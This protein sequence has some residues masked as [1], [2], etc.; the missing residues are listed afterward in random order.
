MQRKCGPLGIPKNTHLIY[1][2]L[3]LSNRRPKLK[4]YRLSLPIRFKLL[5]DIMAHRLRMLAPERPNQAATPPR[6]HPVLGQMSASPLAASHLPSAAFSRRMS[7]TAIAAAPSSPVW[8]A[9]SEL[10]QYRDRSDTLSLNNIRRTL[11]LMEDTIIFSLIERAQFARNE[12]IYQ[13]GGVP[14]P[15]WTLDGHQMSLLEY[16]LRETEQT[17][18]RI[19]RYTSPDENAFFPEALPPLVLPPLSYPQVS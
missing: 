9:P 19:R 18:G 16:L 17:H 12:A 13:R 7:S 14:V 5:I 10:N 15:L 8:S 6:V 4:S 11:I 1:R 2:D 3:S